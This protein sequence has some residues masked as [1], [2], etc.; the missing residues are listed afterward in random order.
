MQK[1]VVFD[2]DGVIHNYRNGWKAPDI[3]D[4]RPVPGIREAI[5]DIHAAGY[6]VVVVSARCRYP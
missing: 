2:F 3:I 4:D 6:R 5:A 1:T